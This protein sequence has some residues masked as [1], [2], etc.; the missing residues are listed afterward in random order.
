MKFNRNIQDLKRD[1]SRIASL[2]T[3]AVLRNKVSVYWWDEKKNFGDLLTPCLFKDYGF[4][5]VHYYPIYSDVVSTGSILNIVPEE[6]SGYIAGSGLM[7]QKTKKFPKAKI[8]GVRG[9]LTKQR[10]NAPKNVTL[11]DPGILATRLIKKRNEKKYSLGLVLHY[12]D[13]L[14]MRFANLV[15]NNELD[16]LMI[17]V[18]RHP[19]KVISDID[20]CEN[21]LSSS[22]H[23]LITA[24]SLGI[25][26]SW[27]TLSNKNNRNQFKYHDYFS[28][29][30][31]DRDPVTVNGYEK[32]SHFLKTVQK[33]SSKID[34][35]K[36]KLNNMFMSLKN[37]LLDDG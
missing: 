31:I 11:G 6:F 3:S 4:T 9:E 33:P 21:I 18:M 19:L 10:I 28:V 25:P 23:G 5:P 13:K 24:D 14:D 7:T 36:E 35:T 27:V 15:R 37:M 20:K 34:E 32:I 26:N 17:D 30:G 29:Y 22:L 16:I 12:D 2:V 8:L 1:I